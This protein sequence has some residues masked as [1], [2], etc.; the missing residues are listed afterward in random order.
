MLDQDL[1][2]SGNIEG[3]SVLVSDMDPTAREKLLRQCSTGSGDLILFAVGQHSSVN[4][5]LD[6]LRTYVA[7]DLGLINHVSLR[8]VLLPDDF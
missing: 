1:Y 8:S 6:R 3:I 7:H 5:T 4:K 2:L